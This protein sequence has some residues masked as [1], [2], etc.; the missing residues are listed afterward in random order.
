LISG[1]CG[2]GDVSVQSSGMRD[3]GCGRTITKE[4]EEKGEAEEKG[5]RCRPVSTSAVSEGDYQI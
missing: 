4:D 3:R 5:K 1:K 2:I